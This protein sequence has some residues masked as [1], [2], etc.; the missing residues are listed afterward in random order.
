MCTT[1][2]LSIHPNVNGHLHSFHILVIVNSAARIK[3]HVSF[4]IIVLSGHIVICPGMRLQGYMA[5]HGEGNGTP[6]QY[7]CLENPMDGGA[8]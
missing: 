2:S 3:V 6:L 4:Q 5:T 8:W 7:S 1:S